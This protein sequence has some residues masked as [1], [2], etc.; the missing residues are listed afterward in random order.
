MALV[1]RGQHVVK[2]LDDRAPRLVLYEPAVNAVVG[3]GMVRPIA[4]RQGRTSMA[5]K[6]SASFS[7]KC[8]RS[9]FQ[10]VYE[11]LRIFLNQGD[12]QW[13]GHI[14]KASLIDCSRPQLNPT[15]WPTTGEK[16]EGPKESL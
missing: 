3:A 16:E 5:R 14:R 15:V 4:H 2:V 13:S 7:R 12:A 10:K 6:P 11:F 8:W 1:G 9:S